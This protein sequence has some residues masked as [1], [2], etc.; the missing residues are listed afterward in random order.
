M[1][2]TP[3][4][5]TAAPPSAPPASVA[6]STSPAPSDRS[7]APAP[8]ARAATPEPAPLVRN[9]FNVQVH[10]DPRGP[11]TRPP[12]STRSSQA[13]VDVLRACARRHGLEV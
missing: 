8:A 7:S 9:T 6:P 1:L 11:P 3:A 5:T 10:L 2:A 12:T 4:P 13:L